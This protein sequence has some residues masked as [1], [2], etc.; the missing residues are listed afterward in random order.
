[1]TDRSRRDFLK[2]S[3]SFGAAALTAGSLAETPAWG[4]DK[5]GL[6]M[7]YGLVTYMWGAKWD[8][9]TLIGNLEESDVLGV[10]LR[11]THAHGVE[12]HLNA[13]Q[14]KEVKKRFDD[15]PVTLVSLGSN[16]RF[17]SPDPKALQRAI[18]ATKEFVKLGHDVGSSGVKVK[19]NSFH[20]NVPHEQTIEQ[21]GKSLNVVGAFG[22]DY[23]QQIRLETHGQCAPPPII[24]QIMDVADNPNVGV[25]WNSNAPDLVGKYD[26]KE[27]NLVYNF[28]LLK[29][30]LGATTHIRTLEW[31]GYPW[32]VLINLFVKI[33][34]AGWLMLEAGGVPEDPVK[35]LVE[36]KQLFKKMVAR[37]RA[38]L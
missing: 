15:S 17:D 38:A 29:D 26:S 24:K 1:M 25:C 2:Q 20:K 6:K 19:P 36:Q 34:Y 5:S 16:E 18:E 8:L 32:Q 33:D 35:A 31:P 13:E 22:A 12:R 30:R 14:R 7:N 37:A 28:N 11:T 27:E 3:I 9:P 23:G 4:A 10:E 21:I